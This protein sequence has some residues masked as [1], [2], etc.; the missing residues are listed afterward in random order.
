MV[1]DAAM[2]GLAVLTFLATNIDGAFLLI[3]FMADPAYRAR[4][5][6]LGQ[7][8]A[9]TCMTLLCVLLAKATLATPYASYFG[10]LGLLQVLI[11][12]KKLYERRRNPADEPIYSLAAAWDGGGNGL[13]VVAAT[14][15]GSFG[16]NFGAYVP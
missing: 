9:S 5:V 7:F 12:V 11:G 16:D 8:L 14:C 4:D 6:V 10:F 2:L 13:R 1:T 3:G 15:V